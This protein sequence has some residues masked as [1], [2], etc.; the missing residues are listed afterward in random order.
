M[1][2]RERFFTARQ[3]SGLESLREREAAAELAAAEGD[4]DL[5][6]T[7]RSS[8]VSYTYYV[9]VAKSLIANYGWLVARADAEP[10]RFHLS[11]WYYK[12]VIP[13]LCSTASVSAEI[14]ERSLADLSRR[15]AA[16]GE[17]KKAELKLRAHAAADMGR[18]DDLRK[19]LVLWEQAGR[20]GLDDCRACDVGS[21]VSF[22]VS[23]G[24]L[25]EALAMGAGFIRG[26][27]RC[28]VEYPG[29][30]YADLSSVARQLGDHRLAKRLRTKGLEWAVGN[31]GTL[32]DIAGFVRDAMYWGDLSLAES[33]V[34]ANQFRVDS[35]TVSDLD[36]FEFA[37]AARLVRE[38]G[39]LFPNAES[40]GPRAE[41]LAAAFDKRNGNSFFSDRLRE[42]GNTVFGSKKP[43]KPA[44]QIET[45]FDAE[46][47]EVGS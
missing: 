2:A 12:W 40:F 31:S 22:L 16:K 20:S 26:L 8:I 27:M 44:P 9:P 29:A 41:T 7:I 28:G 21:H 34:A 14:I 4:L 43:S 19:Y 37:L 38:A 47:S 5:E 1:N 18:I 23:L 36:C 13:K 11:L 35:P 3:M 32:S 39:G 6:W 33:I 25:E 42:D 24:R 46:T 10:T 45:L 30:A 17:S 15:S